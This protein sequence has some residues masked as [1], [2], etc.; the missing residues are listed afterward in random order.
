MALSS[1]TEHD[2]VGT[3]GPARIGVIL[4]PHASGGGALKLLPKVTQE[5]A[6]LNV[7]FSLHVTT[8]PGDCWTRARAFADE[9][10]ERV[11]VIGGD[12]TFNEAVNGLLEADRLIP[13]GIVPAGTGCDLPRT[14]NIPAKSIPDAVRTA[15]LGTPT[16]IDAG[17]AQCDSGEGR[18]FLNIAGL[19]FDATVA[20]RAA[21]MRFSGG[22]SA[23]LA[24]LGMSLAKYHN[25][26]VSITSEDFSMETTAVFV[27]V[28]N[29]KYL[30]GG[31][32]ITPMADVSDGLLDLAIIGDLSIPDLL[33]NL[34]AVYRGKHTNHPKFTHR[35]ITS[36][37]ISSPERAMVQVD[38]EI[39]GSA[40]VVFSVRPSAAL[41]SL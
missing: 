5:L 32:M 26:P 17:H 12:G 16:A 2:A 28:A 8:E 35:Q 1:E 29:A 34:P 22:K 25:I 4:N 6:R 31:F 30:A 23:Y 19:G 3:T 7:K 9:G 14:L 21:R 13:L 10:F 38:G 15:C 39:L 24:A 36:V 40:P 27:T 11:V 33:R 41:V 37:R 18:Y 20:E